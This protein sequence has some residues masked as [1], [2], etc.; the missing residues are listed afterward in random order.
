M[1]QKV[2]TTRTDDIDGTD[3]ATILPFSI[4]GAGYEIDLGPDNAAGLRSIFAPYIAA[5]RI[6]S[7]PRRQ[8]SGNAERR[9]RTRDIRAWAHDKGYEINERGRVPASIA[10]E[11]ETEHGVSPVRGSSPLAPGL[12]ARARVSASG[13]GAGLPEVRRDL[14]RKPPAVRLL[15]AVSPAASEPASPAA[16]KPASPA[17]SPAVELT[18]A[19]S[20]YPP[21]VVADAKA[22]RNTAIRTWAI[23]KGYKVKARGK[24]PAAIVR[25]YDETHTD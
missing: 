1:V 15:P 8:R 22:A 16:S 5:G 21:E 19:V 24:I 14:E 13:T 2:V 12:P 9:G 25:E 4:D 10:R 3:G 11:Y 7:T 18:D 17:T 20:P 6:V 23:R